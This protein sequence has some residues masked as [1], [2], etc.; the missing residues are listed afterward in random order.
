M[1]SFSQKTIASILCVFSA[2][3]LFWA[4]EQHS[5]DYYTLLRWLVCGTSAFCTYLFVEIDKK[6]WASTL[7]IIALLFNPL[8]PVHLS[9]QTWAPIDVV[10]GIILLVSLYPMIKTPITRNEI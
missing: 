10:S 7:G 4:L 9:K 1:I 2:G 3:L 6:V 5:Y 8:I